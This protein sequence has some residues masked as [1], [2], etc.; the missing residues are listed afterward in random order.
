MCP[1]SPLLFPPQLILAGL[2]NKGYPY[3]RLTVGEEHRAHVVGGTRSAAYIYLAFAVISIFFWVQGC[4]RIAVFKSAEARAA[5]AEALSTT[6][7]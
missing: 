3:M 5:A 2:V 6:T 1:H 4:R 7:N